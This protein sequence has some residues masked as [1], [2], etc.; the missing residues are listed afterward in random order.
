[1]QE[2]SSATQPLLLGDHDQRHE[3]QHYSETTD[4]VHVDIEGGGPPPLRRQVSSSQQ[5]DFVSHRTRSGSTP[6]SSSVR[7]TISIPSNSPHLHHTS[8]NDGQA[9]LQPPPPHP[10]SSTQHQHQQH[11]QQQTEDSTPRHYNSGALA[12]RSSP[13]QG[14][15]DGVHEMEVE[16]LTEAVADAVADA[17]GEVVHGAVAEAVQTAIEETRFDF[18]A[19]FNTLVAVTAAVLLERGIWQVYDT[20]F[21]SDGLWSNLSSLFIGLFILI[22]IRLLNLPLA[23]TV[24]GR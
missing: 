15:S 8:N 10:C 1:M 9:P 13:R 11:P 23:T 2:S 22:L 24:P 17:V 18:R 3:S 7:L 19:N 4:T 5:S 21:G 12:L 6:L 14:V 16:I 20:L